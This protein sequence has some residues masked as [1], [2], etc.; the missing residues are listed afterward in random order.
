LIYRSVT[1]FAVGHTCSARAVLAE[2]GSVGGLKTDW[3]P[4]VAVPSV[5]DRGDKV[6]DSLR[7]NMTRRVLEAA[8][9]ARAATSELPAA[10]DTPS[11]S[12]QETC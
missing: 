8:W 11:A 1:E 6:F 2:D 9:L 10:L 7:E 12:G 3:I 5:S 4:A